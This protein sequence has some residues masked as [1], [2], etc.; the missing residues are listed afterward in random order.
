L[1]IQ[2]PRQFVLQRSSFIH[3]ALCFISCILYLVFSLHWVSVSE[4][5]T[6]ERIIVIVKDDIITKTELDEQISRSKEMLRQLYQYEDEAQLSKK[7]EEVGPQILETMIDELLFTQEAVNIGIQ[8]SEADIQQFVINLKEQ[9]G[10][11]EAFQQALKAEGYTIDGF[12][13]EKRRELLRQELIRRKFGSEL[14]VTD[15]DVRK[16]YNENK[17]QFPDRADTVKLKHILIKF[18]ITEADKE[19]ARHRAESILNKLRAGS[20]FGQM[21]T[22]LSDHEPTKVSGGDMGYFTPNMGRHDAKLEESA[23]Q[24][25]VGEISDLIE[26]P[27]GYDIIKV[28]EIKTPQVR[29]QRIYIAAWPDP[30]A[31]KSAEEKVDSILKELMNGADFVELVKKYSDDPLAME[32][33]GDW[34]EMPI[35]AMAPGLKGAFDSFEE[36]EISRRVRTPFGFHIFKIIKRQ[37]LTEDEIAQLREFIRQED[38]RKKISKYSEKLREKAYIHRLAKD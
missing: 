16:F 2:E 33:D 17:E 9:F 28:T 24:L 22:D 18:D 29:A 5:K 32:K 25:A 34:R 36:G 31:E 20:D 13:K 37:D 11:T 19:K 12:R 30:A 7:M 35:D 23:A 3:Y 8:V 26:S 27:G 38:L 6:V 4:A 15:E 10:S 21:A 14:R 1:R